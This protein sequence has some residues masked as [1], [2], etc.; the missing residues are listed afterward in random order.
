LKTCSVCHGVTPTGAGPHGLFAPV[1]NC[2]VDV[3][4]DINSD[5]VVNLADLSSLVSY[6]TGGGFHLPCTTE[7]DINKS[8]AVDLADLS[9]MV[10]YLTG[11][12]YI[13]P[14]CP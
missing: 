5:G 4:G 9:A 8:S 12:G 7:A 14:T 11:G 6:L 2:C 1:T 10:S 3:T 13:L